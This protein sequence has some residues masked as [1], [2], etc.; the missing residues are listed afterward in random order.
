MRLS[1]F[2]AAAILALVTV[3]PAR[4]QDAYYPATTTIP[5]TTCTNQVLSAS[6]PSG[7]TCHTVTTGDTDTTIAKTG[8]DINTSNQ[9]TVTHLAAALPVAQ[10]GTGST[11]AVQT[12]VLCTNTAASTAITG[13][14]KAYFSL[15]C[16]IPANT[17]AAGSRITVDLRGVYSGNAT[18]TLISTLEMCQVS[19]CASGTNVT[20]ATTSAL[21]LLAVSNQYW[22]LDETILRRTA[23]AS[24]TSSTQGRAGYETAGTTMVFDATPNTGTATWDDTVDEYVSAS[25]IFSTNSGSDSITIHTLAIQVQ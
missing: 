8:A 13:N 3:A 22:E 11:T 25:A 16:K 20:L 14:A 23:G 19:G 21:T 4:A 2:V 5:T 9:V 15:N 10:G 1:I 17:L 18:D 12:K 6:A 7:G 24:G